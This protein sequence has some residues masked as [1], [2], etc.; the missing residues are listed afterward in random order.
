[1]INLCETIL[2]P[3]HHRRAGSPCAS[4]YV[5]HCEFAAAD[6]RLVKPGSFLLQVQGGKAAVSRGRGGRALHLFMHF[7]NVNDKY[8]GKYVEG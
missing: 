6:E 1:M 4:R 2:F 3:D 5:D 7:G 8:V